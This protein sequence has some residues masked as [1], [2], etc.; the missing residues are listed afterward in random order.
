M[1]LHQ[2]RIFVT[3]ARYLNMTK[4]SQELHLSQPAL[5][6]Q[7]MALEQEY[8]MRFHL[9]TNQGIDLTEQGR[10]FLEAI[11]PI[12]EQSEN[13]ARSFKTD[14]DVRKR[15]L[16][17]GGSRTVSLTVLP[18]ILVAFNQ[19]YPSVEVM[20]DTD[21]SWRI[22]Q[23]V[24]SAETEIGLV[25][26]ASYSPLLTYESYR[27]HELVAF[28]CS[29][30]PF[31]QKRMTLEELAKIPLVMKRG[32]RSLREFSKRGYK[33]KLALECRAHECVKVAVCK[34]IGV[35][36]LFRDSVEYDQ[37]LKI[38]NVPELETLDCRSYIIYAK[39]K[40]LTPLAQAFLQ[41]LRER[42]TSS[43]KSAGYKDWKILRE[44]SEDQG[45]ACVVLSSAGNRK[46]SG[47]VNAMNAKVGKV[48]F[49]GLGSGFLF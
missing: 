41:L 16:A 28:V 22:E 49:S 5:S 33:P 9:K 8:G 45:S 23:R 19:A 44:G 39:N 36:I 10:A 6:R 26:N 46:R 31:D 47:M 27:E 20:L 38:I 29:K 24:L 7:L 48:I 15:S 1:T 11:R 3:V 37:D 17:V 12:L 34:G 25:M 18:E 32:C 40:P 4:A 30:N 21:D 35:G 14:L 42:R 13:V 43:V 2:I